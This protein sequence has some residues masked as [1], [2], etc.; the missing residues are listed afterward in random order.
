[1]AMAE[2][3]ESHIF[4]RNHTIQSLSAILASDVVELLHDTQHISPARRHACFP[5]ATV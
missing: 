1:M 3:S 5:R 4:C 2:V